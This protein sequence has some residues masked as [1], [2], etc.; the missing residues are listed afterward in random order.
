[1]GSDAS[2]LQH[3]VH[4]LA[5]RGQLGSYERK[6]S[7]RQTIEYKRNRMGVQKILRRSKEADAGAA[8]GS[9]NQKESRRRVRRSREI[10]GAAKFSYPQTLEKARNREG[11]SLAVERAGAGV[12]GNAT[13]DSSGF[14]PQGRPRPV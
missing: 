12:Q 13:S 2:N 5:D 9:R 1:M 10:G 14:I 7:S 6:L 3:L 11:I 4:R 8:T